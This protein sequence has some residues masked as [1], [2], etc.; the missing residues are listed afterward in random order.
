MLGKILRIITNKY[1]LVTVTFLAWSLFFDQNDYMTMQQHKKELNAVKNNIT[2]LN[3]E[4]AQMKKERNDLIT[5]PVMIE[6]Y[7][8]E[9][10]RMKRD[11]EDVYIVDKAY[12]K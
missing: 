2:Y 6:K 7:A 8:R 9:N 11:G 3:T 12:K 5:N 4:I 1:V 10:F